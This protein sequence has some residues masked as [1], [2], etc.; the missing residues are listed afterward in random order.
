MP[1]RHVL[2][3]LHQITMHRHRFMSR[4]PLANGRVRDFGTD[5]AGRIDAYRFAIDP[6]RRS[7]RQRNGPVTRSIT[8]RS[9]VSVATPSRELSTPDISTAAR[10]GS[11]VQRFAQRHTTERRS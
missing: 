8:L 4:N 3:H 11:R 1:S 7:E 10:T 9:A 2:L 5:L 6:S